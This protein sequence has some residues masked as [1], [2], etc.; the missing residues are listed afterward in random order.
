MRARIGTLCA[1]SEN[2]TNSLAMRAGL[3]RGGTHGSEHTHRHRH[4]AAY[5]CGV[6]VL[7]CSIT[8]GASDSHA[9]RSCGPAAKREN[10]FAQC[11]AAN[12]RD[13]TSLS[14]HV[15][16]ITLKVTA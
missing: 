11:F 2:A 15:V 3:I 1:D 13:H 4:P 12:A 7:A 9:Q 8:T 16:G 10:S 5:T 6:N 14:V